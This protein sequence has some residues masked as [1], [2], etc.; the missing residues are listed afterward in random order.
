MRR[1]RKTGV[2]RGMVRET[3]LS[4]ARLVQ[5]MFVQLGEG[6]TPIESMPGIERLSISQAVED[7]GA[8]ARAR[9]PRGAAVRPAGRE[10]RAGLGRLRRRGRRAA[11][12]AGAEGG[13]PGAGGDDRRLPVRLHEPRPLRRRAR[14]RQRGQRR[15]ARAAGP[16]G[17]LA[18]T[19][20]RGRGRPQRHDGR[21]RRRAARAARLRG[22]QGPADHRLLRQV[23]LGLLRA[24]P[25]GGRLDARVRRPARLPDGPRQRR[26]GRARGA[27]G[28]RARAPTW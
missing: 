15:L 16:H 21:P 23:R 11:G 24:V 27:A 18:R 14:R 7:A 12:G 8:G 28:R 5:P 4:P 19:R 10:G 25:R 17:Q 9:H 3:E 1:L 6:R 26:G 13:A 2:L 20:G 22:L